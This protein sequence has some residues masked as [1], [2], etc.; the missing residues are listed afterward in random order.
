[1]RGLVAAAALLSLA[2]C[3]T[4]I[5]VPKAPIGGL[6]CAPGATYVCPCGD[7]TWASSWKSGTQHCG[8][9]FVVTACDC[10]GADG[11]EL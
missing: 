3:S 1:M 6:L 5:D 4:E 8:P 2:A 7:E 11:G 9:D 10:S